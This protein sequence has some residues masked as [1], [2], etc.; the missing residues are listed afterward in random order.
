M[1]VAAAKLEILPLA[2][3]VSML[4]QVS[5]TN[6][7]MAIF[8]KWF[9]QGRLYLGLK[10]RSISRNPTLSTVDIGSISGARQNVTDLT[11]LLYYWD[12]ADSILV[13]FHVVSKESCLLS[14]SDFFP[15]VPVAA[16]TM[17]W[18][19]RCLWHK[20]LYKLL[21]LL[22]LANTS[23]SQRRHLGFSVDWPF[24]SG[25]NLK[26]FQM[27]AFIFSFLLNPLWVDLFLLVLSQTTVWLTTVYI[28][29]LL[30]FNCGIWHSF[31]Q[32]LNCTERYI[33]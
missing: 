32:F 5:E 20:W 4:L 7:R 31:G 25:M 1:S 22:S 6:S 26:Y 9:R 10:I 17:L 30:G 15:L 12:F 28:Q 18:V 24:S 16:C 14:S 11:S 3:G 33:I 2:I 21:V 19:S 13:L 8:V 23:R 27:N 29:N